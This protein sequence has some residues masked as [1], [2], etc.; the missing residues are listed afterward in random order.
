M[1]PRRKDGILYNE[2]S[3]KYRNRYG[4][5]LGHFRRIFEAKINY[6][7]T[8]SNFNLRLGYMIRIIEY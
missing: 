7:C 5:R 2:T 8:F 4:I 1:P 3:P 6:K